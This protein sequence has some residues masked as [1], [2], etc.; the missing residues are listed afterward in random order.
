MSLPTPKYHK[1]ENVYP[2]SEDTFVL[3]DALEKDIPKQVQQWKEQAKEGRSNLRKSVFACEVGVGSGVC[4][5]FL[6]GLLRKLG[7]Q[8]GFEVGL[9][10]VAFS[11]E[12]VFG[13]TFSNHMSSI[14]YTNLFGN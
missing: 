7:E 4:S 12:V 6:D 11:D 14:D 5:V 8:E 2:P 1:H 13:L 3:L 10:W 9:G